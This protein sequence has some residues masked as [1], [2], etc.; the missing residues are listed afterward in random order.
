MCHFGSHRSR[1]WKKLTVDYKVQ[2]CGVWVYLFKDVS[3]E[4]ERGTF[5]GLIEP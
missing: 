1:I 5:L 3:G 2:C 4:S